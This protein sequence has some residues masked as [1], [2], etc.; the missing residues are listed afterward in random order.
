MNEI[1]L[2]KADVTPFLSFV[3]ARFYVCIC[4][5]IY[6]K[7]EIKLEL[8]SSREQMRLIRGEK[9]E[10]SGLWRGYTQR[11]L[12]SYIKIALCNPV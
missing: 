4:M 9:A 12:Y 2:R 8:R 11:I 10:D 7:L 5:C 3:S 1:S 6:M